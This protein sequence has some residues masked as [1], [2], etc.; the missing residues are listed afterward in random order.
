MLN[1]E[2]IK[3]PEKIKLTRATA[4]S[5]PTEFLKTLKADKK[6]FTVFENFSPSHRREYNVSISEAKTELTRNK[7]I[8]Q[9]I[10][11]IRDG[12]GRNW[13]Y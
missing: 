1:E 10:E 13:K 3:L 6:A 2:G 11:W 5:T 12:K 4:P 7:R 8:A 9:A